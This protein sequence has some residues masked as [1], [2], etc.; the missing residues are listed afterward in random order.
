MD[1]FVKAFEIACD[2]HRGQL[3]KAGMPYILHPIRLSEKFETPILKCVAILHDV[4][5][6]TDVTE[7]DLIDKG[8]PTPVITAVKAITKIE[9][10]DY[11][12]YIGRV[13][14][15]LYAR[16]VKLEDLKDNI[17]TLRLPTLND[18]ELKR[19]KKYHD[20]Y[21]FLSLTNNP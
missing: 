5:E 17:N 3:D 2:A 20:A 1:Y 15:N 9:G 12:S 4:I 8:I 10:E 7:Y 6:D 19:V 16:S 21:K 11:H 18:K 13:R 14:S